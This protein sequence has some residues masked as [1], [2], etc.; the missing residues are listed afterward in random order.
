MDAFF[1][2][3]KKIVDS[4]NEQYEEQY[5][6]REREGEREECTNNANGMVAVKLMNDDS[7]QN[8]NIM[9][10]GLQKRAGSFETTS[11]NSESIQTL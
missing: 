9:R 10:D 4:N 5:E 8:D 6:E 7:I 2:F 11:A 3:T 1:H